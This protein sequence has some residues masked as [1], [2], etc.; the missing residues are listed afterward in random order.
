M[1]AK[2]NTL[3]CFVLPAGWRELRRDEIIERGDKFWGADPPCDPPQFHTAL[4]VG[5]TPADNV[6][7]YRYIRRQ[8][9][10]REGGA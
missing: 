10:S 2:S 9:V 6:C 7:G 3:R 1:S 4:S 8:N 5:W